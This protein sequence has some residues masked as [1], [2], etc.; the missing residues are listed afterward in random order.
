M[1]TY[2]WT[3]TRDEYALI[4]GENP[5]AQLEQ[6]LVT[7]FRERPAAVVAALED[8]A[9]RRA[10]GKI[11][12]SA[13]AY[14]RTSVQRRADS[15]DVIVTDHDERERATKRADAYLRNVCIH[16]DRETEVLADLFDRGG[17]LAPFT[18]DDQL[19]QRIVAR[20][21][22]LRPIGEKTEADQAEYD[23][24]LEQQAERWKAKRREALNAAQAEVLARQALADTE[25]L[26]R[27][28]DPTPPEPVLEQEPAL[29]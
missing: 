22:E 8:A 26:L 19:R 11:T 25:Q 13:W 1:T 7:H 24:Q 4:F 17:T 27:E 3:E 23:E 20:W 28:T 16:Y 29:A 9:A 12:S 15:P 21:R 18:D 2:I 5:G 10:A 6:D 14:V